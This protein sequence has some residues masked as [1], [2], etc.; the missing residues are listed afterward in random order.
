MEFE[1]QGFSTCGWL[2][3]TVNGIS[4]LKSK[5]KEV[6]EGVRKGKLNVLGVQ[7]SHM[8]G[9]DVMVYMERKEWG[10][11]EG[12]EGVEWCVVWCR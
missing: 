1:Q 12:K 2:L 9:S 6:L 4:V 7:E 11:C 3:S 10:M 5:R 8:Q